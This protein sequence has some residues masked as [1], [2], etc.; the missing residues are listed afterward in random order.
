LC[1]RELTPTL[2]RS[3]SKGHEVTVS[4]GV[5]WCPLLALGVPWWRCGLMW[6]HTKSAY[7]S[8]LDKST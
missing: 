3:A 4:L 2:A 7:A 6:L 1:S 8:L 5:P